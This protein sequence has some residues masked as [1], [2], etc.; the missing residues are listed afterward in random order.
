MTIIGG[1]IMTLKTTYF[2]N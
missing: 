1:V 2:F